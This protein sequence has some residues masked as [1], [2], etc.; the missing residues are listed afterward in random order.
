VRKMIGQGQW[1]GTVARDSGQGQWPGTV[2]RDSGQGQWPG[3]VAREL[4]MNQLDEGDVQDLGGKRQ[5][6]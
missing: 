6:L 1:P 2:A 4:K 3:T 5:A